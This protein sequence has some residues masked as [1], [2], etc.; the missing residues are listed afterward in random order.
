MY[1]GVIALLGPLFL[2]ARNVFCWG[3]LQAYPIRISNISKNAC[4][5]AHVCLTP[6]FTL[7]HDSE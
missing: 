6:N 2:Y 4:N 7:A 1:T 3:V 5:L